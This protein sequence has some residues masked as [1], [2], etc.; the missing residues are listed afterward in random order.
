MHLTGTRA[1]GAI[2]FQVSI[3]G[4]GARVVQFVLND[5][6][7][8]P[9]QPTPVAPT[10]TDVAAFTASDFSTWPFRSTCV[11]DINVPAWLS[12]SP[13]VELKAYQGGA[14]LPNID[15]DGDTLITLTGTSGISAQK[16]F[17]LDLT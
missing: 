11:L 4:N 9:I 8:T 1:G 6:S 10:P 7:G 14:Q 17:D 2:T 12:G 13:V 3:V 16:S 15:P 5:D